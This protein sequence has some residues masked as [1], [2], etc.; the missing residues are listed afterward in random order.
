MTKKEWETQPRLRS[1][2][3]WV[4]REY[5]FVP[6]VPCTHAFLLIIKPIGSVKA[7]CCAPI[8]TI[9]WTGLPSNFKAIPGLG[10]GSGPCSL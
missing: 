1:T 10:G 8:F 9:N 3:L 4:V 5:W 6:V 7:E 2:C